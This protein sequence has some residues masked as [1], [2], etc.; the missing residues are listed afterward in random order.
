[1]PRGGER[2]GSGPKPKPRDEKGNVLQMPGTQ[3]KVPAPIPVLDP[4][5]QAALRVPPAELSDA[6]KV[7]WTQWADQAMAERTLT[8]ATAAGFQHLCQQWVYVA[9]LVGKI[10]HLGPDTKEAVGY[11][12]GYQKLVQRLDASLARF[13]LTAF[14]KPAISDKPKP[15]ANPWAAVGMK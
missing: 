5:E 2:P 11:L 14:G 9:A 3:G 15:A 8:P 10:N 13:K 4:G 7:V 1:M 6:A 12:I